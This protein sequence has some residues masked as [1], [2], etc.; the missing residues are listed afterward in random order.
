LRL[1]LASVSVC[2]WKLLDFCPIIQQFRCDAPEV[3]PQMQTTA[4]RAK[5]NQSFLSGTN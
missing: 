1:K 2:L 4:L 3:T 5:K